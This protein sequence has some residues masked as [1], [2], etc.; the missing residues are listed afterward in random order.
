MPLKI[1]CSECHKKISVDE[2]FAGSMCRCP[3]CKSIILVPKQIA[4]AEGASSR[5]GSPAISRPAV[6]T[7]GRPTSP[8]Q[9][10]APLHEVIPSPILREMKQKQFE[11]PEPGIIPGSK[12]SY[13]RSMGSKAASSEKPVQEKNAVP[14]TAPQAKSTEAEVILDAVKADTSKLSKEQIAAI[15]T[16]NPIMFQGIVSL[17]LI[18]ILVAMVGACVYLG[19]KMFST[20]EQQNQESAEQIYSSP[21]I[22]REIQETSYATEEVNPFEYK[23]GSGLL[24]NQFKAAAPVVFCIDAG[25]SMGDRYCMARDMVRA[26]V[27]SMDPSQQFAVVVNQDSGVNT[28][29]PMTAGGI[30]GEAKIRQKL[31]EKADDGTV[32][33][34]G[35]PLLEDA[36]IA[37]ADLK[38]KTVVLFIADKDIDSPKRL[39]S[40]LQK[41]GAELIIVSLD[42]NPGQEAAIQ[43]LAKEAGSKTKVKLYS[44]EE[45]EKSYEK[46]DL[47]VD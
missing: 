22:A 38:P 17:I 13:I 32:T 36:V 42:T 18:V 10:S 29:T 30:D 11:Q 12:S 37:A 39:V 15:P 5:P 2:A 6:P 45:L 35:A 14:Q 24:C 33:L 9:V 28:I 23:T 44:A 47:P 21:E 27:L 16:A 4:R 46:S 34:G 8:G 41:A 25:T 43:Q 1:R 40:A 31:M 19:Y 7:V 26:S 3:Y 20:Q